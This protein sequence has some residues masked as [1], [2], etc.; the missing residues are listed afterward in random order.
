MSDVK[1]SFSLIYLFF[2]KHEYLPSGTANVLRAAVK[3]PI[4]SFQNK[5]GQE[6]SSTL[7]EHSVEIT[8]E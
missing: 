2:F 3:L 7:V 1:C 8:C 6:K 4:F 5:R